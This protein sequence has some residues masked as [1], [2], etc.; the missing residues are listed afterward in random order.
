LNDYYLIAEIKD[1]YNIHGSVIIKSFSDFSERFFQLEKVF[2]NFFGK[3]KELQIEFVEKVNSTLIMK[4]RRFNSEEDVLFLVGKKLY[5][6]KE[7]LY[8]LPEDTYY[9][10]DLVGSDTYIDSKFFGK[11]VDVLKLH[12]NDVYVIKK[13]DGSEI[14][15][16]A[17]EEFI[18]KILLD[19]NKIFLDPKCVM[20]DE[21]EN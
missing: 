9:I 16:P 17:V 7:N 14:L 13:D 6:N 20:F 15:I 3:V 18:E 12:S 2:I 19:E 11:M 8:E 21:N 1:I 10:H 4:F 5:I